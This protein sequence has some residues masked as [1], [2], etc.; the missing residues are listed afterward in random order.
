MG[1][2]AFCRGGCAL[3]LAGIFVAEPAAA[4]V[5]R[6]FVGSEKRPGLQGEMCYKVT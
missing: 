6:R 1:T 5:L 2:F 3:I 4:D